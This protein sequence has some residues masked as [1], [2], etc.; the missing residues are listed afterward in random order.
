MQEIDGDFEI[1]EEKTEDNNVH[2]LCQDELDKVIKGGHK[3]LQINYR[4]LQ[5][6]PESILTDPV[7]S[8][9]QKLHLKRNLLKSLYLDIS[10]NVLSHL[11]DSIGE[12]SKLRKLQVSNNRL[13]KI[14]RSIGKLKR[15][16]TLELMNNEIVTL[17]LEICN[18]T[19][20]ITLN[21]DNNKL[22]LLPRQLYQLTNL[23]ELSAVGNNLLV[24]PNDLGKMSC[25]QSLYMDNN[26]YLCT[27]PASAIYKNVGFHSCGINEP[28]VE[29]KN[30]FCH[31]V[32]RH[33]ETE[34]RSIL[35]PAEIKMAGSGENTTLPLLELYL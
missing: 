16:E 30:S 25:L 18:C 19:S 8:K 6:L 10:S 2:A 11:P 7:F 35:L 27:V 23:T 14:P 21:V 29:M 22:Q 32:I 20:L 31:V 33:S 5:E 26:P 17:P 28:T 9:L 3:V 4:R 13:K 24:L 1:L 15:L 12:L 34:D